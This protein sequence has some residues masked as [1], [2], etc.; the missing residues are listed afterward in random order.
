MARQDDGCTFV[1]SD[2]VARTPVRCKNR[3]GIEIA[4]VTH[5]AA[6][7]GM[8]LFMS[9]VHLHGGPAPVRR[10]L[11]E[12]L[13]L[14]ANGDIIRARSSTSRFPWRRPPRATAPWTSDAPSRHS[15]RSRA[16]TTWSTMEA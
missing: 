11:P 4:G 6:L 8:D 5:D 3:F 1:L 7:G 15:S 12:H 16:G 13:Q 10:F 2:E 9:L 14:I